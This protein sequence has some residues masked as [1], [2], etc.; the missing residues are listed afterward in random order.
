MQSVAWIADELVLPKV[1][2]AVMDGEGTEVGKIAGN[3]ADEPIQSS[4]GMHYL[5]RLEAKLDTCGN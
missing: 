3:D 5:N 4:R 2:L 1:A